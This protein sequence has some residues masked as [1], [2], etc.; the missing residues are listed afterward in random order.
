MPS[1]AF[2][3]E[4]LSNVVDKSRVALI[5]CLTLE[6]NWRA[7]G[8]AGTVSRCRHDTGACPKRDK[9][10]HTNSGMQRHQRLSIIWRAPVRTPWL[11]TWPSTLSERMVATRKSG[12]R[13]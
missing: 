9:L 1:G 6:H 4:W 5:V 10:L 13:R 3:D 2:G 12:D 7:C 11:G 8:I